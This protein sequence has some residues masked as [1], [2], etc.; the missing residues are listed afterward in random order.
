MSFDRRNPY[1]PPPR[2]KLWRDFLVWVIGL[3]V[4]LL[5]AIAALG[6]M[7]WIGTGSVPTAAESD[8]V[9]TLLWLS[10]LLLAYPVAVVYL[11]LD[12]RDGL[13]ANRAWEVMSETERA[14]ALAAQAAPQAP[15][16]QRRKHA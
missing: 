1:P 13:R 15:S 12:L 4:G 11:A 5:L 6:L 9:K 10:F 16:R 14:A 7:V 2:K 8:M 3:P